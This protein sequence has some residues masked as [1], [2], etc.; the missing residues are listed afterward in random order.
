[1]ILSWGWLLLA[2][3]T[4][5]A[6]TGYLVWKNNSKNAI[7]ITIDSLIKRGYLRSRTNADGTVEILKHNDEK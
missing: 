5:S 1:M 3:S 4:G 2:Y 7:D 6:V